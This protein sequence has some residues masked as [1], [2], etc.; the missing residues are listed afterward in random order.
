MQ[1]HDSNVLIHKKEHKFNR[2]KREEVIPRYKL[3]SPPYYQ[4]E[5]ED[6]ELEERTHNFELQMHYVVEQE[7]TT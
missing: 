7:A 2:S 3:A 6:E 5:Q 4:E 1:Q